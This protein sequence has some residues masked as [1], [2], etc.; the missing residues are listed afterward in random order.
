[1]EARIDFKKAMPEVRKI[2]EAMLGV[3]GAL[4][5]GPLTTKLLDLV[6]MR[7]SQINGCA[8]CLDMHSKELR[9][10]GETEQRIFCLEGWKECP[11]YSDKERAALAWTEAVTLLTKDY[12]PDEVYEKVRKQFTET[13]LVYLTAAIGA[14]NFWNRLNV[15][16]RTVA[17]SYQSNQSQKSS[18]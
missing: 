15:S 6:R 5:A 16:L 18:G 4:N 9:A 2:Y 3:E 12:V 10:H 14:I 17:G 11:F 1:M 13:E 8:Y 7:A